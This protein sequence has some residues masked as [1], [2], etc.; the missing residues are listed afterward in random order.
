MSHN[1]TITDMRASDIFGPILAYQIDHGIKTTAKQISLDTGIDEHRI[2][3]LKK[4]PNRA[5]V[6]ELEALT[7]EYHYTITI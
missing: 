6:A 1:V 3:T 5:T 4:Y 7:R 2:G